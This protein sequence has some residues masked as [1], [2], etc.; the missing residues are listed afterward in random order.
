[1]KCVGLCGHGASLPPLGKAR[2]DK[3]VNP[4]CFCKVQNWKL[5]SKLYF[6]RGGCI[7]ERSMSQTKR[8]KW[9]LQGIPAFLGGLD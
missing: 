3:Y 9:A 8:L 5:S 6:L 4:L 7:P 1:M 2:G